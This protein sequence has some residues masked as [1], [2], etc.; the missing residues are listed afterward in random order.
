[1][2]PSSAP[3]AILWVGSAAVVPTVIRLVVDHLVSD[4]TI[5]PAYFPFVLAAA[6]FLG[7]R[8]AVATAILSALAANF[9][10]M[11]P[12]FAFSTVLTDVV[13]TLMFLLSAGVVIYGVERLKS[14][15]SIAGPE[16]E[17]SPSAR[18]PLARGPGLLL[19]VVLAL[20]TWVAVIW[21]AVRAVRMFT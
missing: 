16:Y 10:F 18:R 7:W 21:G 4:V 15:A 13:S 20:V 11:G 1:M 19:A 2:A 12:R 5:F 3:M 14:A 17:N 9:M 6:T 8:S